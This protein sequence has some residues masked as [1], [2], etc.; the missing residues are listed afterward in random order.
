MRLVLFALALGCVVAIAEKQQPLQPINREAFPEEKRCSELFYTTTF[1]GVTAEQIIF[2]YQASDGS[3]K[4]D[5]VPRKRA[6]VRLSEDLTYERTTTEDGVG[7]IFRLSS[8]EYSKAHEC[9]PEPS[10]AMP[11]SASVSRAQ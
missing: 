1:R 6:V 3:T 4:R 7:A 5:M 10:L 9:L 2:S 11:T 8:A